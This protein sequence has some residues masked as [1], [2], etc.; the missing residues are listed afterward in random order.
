LAIGCNIGALEKEMAPQVV[1]HLEARPTERGLT[2]DKASIDYGDARREQD[3]PH[4]CWDGYVYLGYTDEDGEEQIEKLP[5]RRC[6]EDV[7]DV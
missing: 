6:A 2:V 5:C 1:T 7:D 3:H 4:A